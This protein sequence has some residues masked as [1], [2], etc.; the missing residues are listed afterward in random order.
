MPRAQR[1]S[2]RAGVELVS[3]SVTVTDARGRYVSGLDPSDFT[4]LE[5]GRPQELVFFSTA[6]TALTVSLLIDS[7]ASMEQQLPMAQKAAAE[8][9]GRLHPG[10]TAQIVDFD[11]RVQVL[12]AF[13]DERDVLEQAIWSVTAGGS[14]AL[15]NAIYIALRQLETQPA[16]AGDNMRRRVVVVLSDGQ[17]TSSLVTFDELLDIAKRSHVAIYPI[18][19]G[20][21]VP[22]P[23]QVRPDTEFELRRLAQETGGRLLVAKDGAA[24]SNVYG[25]IADELTS[26]Y[27]LGYLSNNVE[28][29]DG[30]RSIA[31]RV[32]RPNVQVRART[33]YQF[34]ARGPSRP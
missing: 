16:A 22:R 17:D 7:S 34:T 14:T 9:V 20:P 32:G 2:F 29:G 13:T 3:M 6:I 4:V 27:F 30:W 10:D 23:G 1:P 18:R 5:D 12:Q 15:Y 26:Q 28:R 11:S 31:V 24:L 8:F 21:V 19:L 25:Q 33:G